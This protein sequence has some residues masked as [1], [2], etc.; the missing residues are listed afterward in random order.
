MEERLRCESQNTPIDF[1]ALLRN[2]EKDQDQYSEDEASN[3][4]HRGER[5]NKI[6]KLVDDYLC[7]IL[8][9]QKG[10]RSESLN[11]RNA[12]KFYGISHPESDHK[13]SCFERED[14]GKSIFL[15]WRPFVSGSNFFEFIN[16]YLEL[17]EIVENKTAEYLHAPSLSN[18]L[19]RRRIF[20]LRALPDDD[21]EIKKFDLNREFDVDQKSWYTNLLFKEA[22]FASQTDSDRLIRPAEVLLIGR[23]TFLRSMLSLALWSY[24]PRCYYETLGGNQ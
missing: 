4:S 10:E 17:M 14:L 18:S 8:N 13:L 7:P 21:K 3:W 6:Q 12:E 15:L 11:R 22:V 1:D 2:W 19:D 5:V 9:W 16:Y 24:F 23:K 20:G